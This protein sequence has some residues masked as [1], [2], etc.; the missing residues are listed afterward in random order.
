MPA[1]HLKGDGFVG[2][3]DAKRRAVYE[4]EKAA[5][6]M[7][8]LP[9]DKEKRDAIIERLERRLAS[10]GVGWNAQTYDTVVRVDDLGRA[11]VIPLSEGAGWLDGT[12]GGQKTPTRIPH[13]FAKPTI[14]KVDPRVAAQR[15]YER[16]RGAME[17]TGYIPGQL[18]KE[19]QA[20]GWRLGQP[21]T[22]ERLEQWARDFQETYHAHRRLIG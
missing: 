8:V 3:T 2:I 20:E 21:V 19:L 16:I 9:D 17:R 15:F 5:A 7:G 13:R 6:A 18:V 1:V 14:T 4:A 10:R 11:R 12:V 22:L